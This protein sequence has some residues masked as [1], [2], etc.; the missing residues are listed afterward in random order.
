M[1][2]SFFFSMCFSKYT[3]IVGEGL[4]PGLTLGNLLRISFLVHPMQL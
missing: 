1:S 4:F 3:S 2:R